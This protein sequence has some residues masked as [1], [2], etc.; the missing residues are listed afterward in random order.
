[1]DDMKKLISV[2]KLGYSHSISAITQ[3]AD[4]YSDDVAVF[5][6]NVELCA[7]QRARCVL[8][9]LHSLRVLHSQRSDRGHSVAAVRGKGLQVCRGTGAAGGIKSG[10]AQK[11]WG[12]RIG[13]IVVIPHLVV[14]CASTPE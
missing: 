11:N 8:H 13:M 4:F 5:G 12:S 7:Q 2:Q 9:V 3:H 6:K 14:L 10:N 1:M